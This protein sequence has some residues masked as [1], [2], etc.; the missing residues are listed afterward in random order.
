MG[1]RQANEPM[2]EPKRSSTGFV[3]AAPTLQGGGE[4]GGLVSAKSIRDAIS[5]LEMHLRQHRFYGPGH[6]NSEKSFLVFEDRIRQA[7]QEHG[8]ISIQVGPYQF[9]WERQVVYENKNTRESLSYKFFTSGLRQ[10]SISSGVETADLRMLAK[11]LAVDPTRMSVDEDLATTL[12]EQ[13]LAGINFHLASEIKDETEGEL[14]QADPNQDQSLLVSNDG[15]P[16]GGHIESQIAE[17]VRLIQQQ[18][19][20]GKWAET[21]PVRMEDNPFTSLD[22]IR[23]HTARVVRQE[24]EITRIVGLGK[25]EVERLKEEVTGLEKVNLNK[26][27][28]DVLYVLMRDAQRAEDFAMLEELFT[29]MCESALARLDFR[30]LDELIGNMRS[31]THSVMQNVVEESMQKILRKL[32]SPESVQRVREGMPVST[33]PVDIVSFSRYLSYLPDEAVPEILKLFG[34]TREPQVRQ[35]L[36]DYISAHPPSSADLFVQLVY[37]RPDDTEAILDLIK[38][39]PPSLA[40]AVFGKMTNH[41]DPRVKVAAF[42][43]I[44][45]APSTSVLQNLLND[46]SAVVRQA[47]LNRLLSVG[48]PNIAGMLLANFVEP[49]TFARLPEVEQHLIFEVCG[50]AGGRAAIPHLEKSLTT[51]GWFGAKKKRRIRVLSAEGLARMNIE[52]ARELIRAG[53]L[54]DDEVVSKAC[55]TLLEN[56]N[57]RI[58][59]ANLE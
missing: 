3:P 11:L 45:G 38:R 54:D 39:M 27:F 16:A 23:D 35:L 33:E 4:A 49:G 15:G 32:T 25:E 59:L 18:A 31:Q 21:V 8:D 14:E 34:A 36:A 9:K 24:E 47:V 13:S 26:K 19:I 41:A 30:A 56:P 10:I 17:V 22:Q 37:E 1:G 2:T 50:R 42:L 5:A 53:A 6:P 57:A 52:R 28:V 44:E 55:A 48:T 12:W 58:S 43:A 7:M 29:Q 46:D 20:D 40:K 51:K